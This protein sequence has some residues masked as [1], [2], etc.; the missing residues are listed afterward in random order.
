MCIIK[1][2]IFPVL[3]T[4]EIYTA[5]RGGYKAARKRDVRRMAQGRLPPNQ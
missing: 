1:I 5:P 4:N 3:K 2:Y